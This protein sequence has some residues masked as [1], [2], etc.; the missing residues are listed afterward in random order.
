MFDFIARIVTRSE[1]TFL[2][3]IDGARSAFIYF[4]GYR[5]G[6]FKTTVPRT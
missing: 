6:L 4:G 5:Y 1:F 2:I 3:Y